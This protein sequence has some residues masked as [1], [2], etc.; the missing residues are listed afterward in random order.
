MKYIATVD[1]KDYSVEVQ[2]AG[3]AGA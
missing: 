3:N 1:G 2:A